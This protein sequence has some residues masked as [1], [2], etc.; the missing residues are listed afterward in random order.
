MSP[1][2]ALGRAIL[3]YQRGNLQGEC[4]FRD[5]D[6]TKDANLHDFYFTGP[7][8]WSADMLSLLESLD[9]PILDAGCA[10][11]KYARWL[12][13]D[14]E[15]V[16]IDVSPGAVTAAR[17][18]GVNDVREM[19][20]F[21]MAFPRDRFRT[22]F[23]VGTQSG[24]AGSMAGIRE[25]LGDL[26]FV[27]D[28]EGTAIVDSY[29]PTQLTPDDLFGYRPDP[30]QGLARRAFHFEYIRQPT[31]GDDERIVG[32]TLDFVLFSPERLEEA[33]IGTPWHLDHVRPGE[34]Y[35]KAVLEK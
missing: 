22:A 7:D 24:L 5:G 34:G 18:R 32:P 8:D 27:T 19:D 26:A 11:G 28:S 14:H 31:D 16:A 9:S 3:D 10:A 13:D 23:V 6:E 21:D 4:L 33:T 12:Q 30:R 20:M 35:Y 17:E 1:S 25:S 29:D 2:D 15:I